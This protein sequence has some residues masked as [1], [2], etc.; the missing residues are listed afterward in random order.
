MLYK[1]R[2]N[3]CHSD[4]SPII[5]SLQG[6]SFNAIAVVSIFLWLIVPICKI[7]GYDLLIILGWAINSVPIGFKTTE[8]LFFC[9]FTNCMASFLLFSEIKVT[10]EAIANVL[11]NRKYL[12]MFLQVNLLFVK[13]PKS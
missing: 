11:I 6:K 9:N 8:Y 13:N 12:K 5:L 1:L 10:C 2:V 3:F 7:V 4:N